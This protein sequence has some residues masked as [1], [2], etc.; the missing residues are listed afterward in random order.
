MSATPDVRRIANRRAAL[1]REY[2]QVRGDCALVT[3]TDSRHAPY[4]FNAMAS[5]HERFP[6][7][8]CLEIFD[9]GMSGSQK[10]E[11][12]RVDWA[13]VRSIEPFVSHWK[14]NWSWKPYILLQVPQRY[15]FYFDASN[16]V[17]FR[18][19]AL[20]FR[21]IARQGYLLFE[22]GQRL[23]QTTPPGYWELFGGRL[24]E[25][26]DAPTFGAGLM[27]FDRDTRANTAIRE[28]LE[29]TI[30]GWT[31]GC[32]PGETRRAY[33]RS[34]VRDCECF[35][36][37]QTLFNLAFRKHFGASLVLR[38]ELKYCGHGGPHDHPRQFL[39]YSRRRR[40]SLIYFWRP[41]GEARMVFAFN[42]LTSYA[43]ITLRD[44]AIT[45]FRRYTEWRCRARSRGREST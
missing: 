4:L 2:L 27:G 18:S 7:H 8:P 38:N 28:V 20:W 45:C 44:F 34:V 14:R 11:L 15:V 41:I 1:H 31:L 35:R 42:R 40:D 26:S 13:R 10:Q 39:W 43:L 37:D 19:L 30:E 17:L 23:C 16:I 24:E 25:F 22:N 32:S 5:I 36:A 29:R 9:L 6:E 33:D 3:A 21:I 12:S